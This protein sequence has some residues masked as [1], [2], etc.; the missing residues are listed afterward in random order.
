MYIYI[1][2]ICVSINKLYTETYMLTVQAVRNGLILN[3]VTAGFIH[4]F[5]FVADIWF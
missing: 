2:Y 1:T 4:C 3:S 5:D